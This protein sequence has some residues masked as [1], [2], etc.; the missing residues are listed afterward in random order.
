[1]Y[2]FTNFLFP[3]PLNRVYCNLITF[4]FIFILY[5]Y[6]VS[7]IKNSWH[8]PRYVTLIL[9]RDILKGACPNNIWATVPLDLKTHAKT[10]EY[11]CIYISNFKRRFELSSEISLW[12]NASVEVPPETWYE[13]I[14]RNLLKTKIN[15]YLEKNV[16]FTC[17]PMANK[18]TKK[19]SR[20]RWWSLKII[21][22]TTVTKK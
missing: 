10:P 15:R 9:V 11:R 5:M 4:Y 2:N 22:T 19:S 8:F 13:E 21:T 3:V 17:N 16:I 7:F 20:Q 18:K 1:M 12:T 6:D 14:W